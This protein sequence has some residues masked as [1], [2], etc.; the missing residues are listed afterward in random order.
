MLRYYDQPE[1][2]NLQNTS[3]IYDIIPT[4][5]EFPL[6]ESKDIDYNEDD[7]ERDLHPQTSIIHSSM[8]WWIDLA[9]VSTS[10]PIQCY[11]RNDEEIFTPDSIGESSKCCSSYYWDM[12]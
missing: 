7:K 5:L 6:K 2:R 3:D 4:H 1:S 12:Y 8:Q 9:T 10:S 11:E